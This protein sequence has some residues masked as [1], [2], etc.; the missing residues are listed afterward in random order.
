MIQ[1][2][3]GNHSADKY[4]ASFKE[5]KDDTRYNTAAL[6]EKFEQGLNPVLADKIYPL[7]E[8]P[9]TLNSWISWAIK[10]NRQWRQREA[11][12]KLLGQFPKAIFNWSTK[13]QL[14]F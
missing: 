4:V 11:N 6:I 14:I 13:T 7:P 9:T 12:K 8:M 5:L 10:L 3:Q 2:R 1:L